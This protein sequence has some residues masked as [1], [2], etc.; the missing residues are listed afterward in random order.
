MYDL[1]KFYL[2][3]QCISPGRTKTNILG[4]AMEP[5][6]IAMDASD[7]TSAIVNALSASPVTQV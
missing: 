2:L 3:L 1:N 4:S 5:E 7:I 6:V